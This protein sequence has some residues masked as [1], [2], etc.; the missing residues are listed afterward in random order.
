MIHRI[1]VGR[2][3]TGRHLQGP[4]TRIVRLW[5][6]IASVSPVPSATLPR[7]MATGDEQQVEFAALGDAGDFLDHREVVVADR[8][9]LAAP[10]GRMVA[11]AEHKDAEMHL[12]GCRGQGWSSCLL[13][14]G[15]HPEKMNAH[16][17]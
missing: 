1:Q 17:F 10:A 4:D 6:S 16:G 15:A 13:L 7:S 3:S 12:T 9:V 11:G 8:G 5:R 14:D 2:P